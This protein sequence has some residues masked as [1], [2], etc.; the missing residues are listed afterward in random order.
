M[1]PSDYAFLSSLVGAVLYVP[2]VPFLTFYFSSIFSIYDHKLV[3]ILLITPAD[4]PIGISK[5]WKN[6]RLGKK[7]KIKI[8][9]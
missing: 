8:S 1:K 3:S 4:C 9:I 2:F 7:K 5:V 6:L